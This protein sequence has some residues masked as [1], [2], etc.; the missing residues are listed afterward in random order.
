LAALEGTDVEKMPDL[1]G[2]IAATRA[3]AG[4]PVNAT[5]LA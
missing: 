5:K 1:N 2:A 4:L 3:A